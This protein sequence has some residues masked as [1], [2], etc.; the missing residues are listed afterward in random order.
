MTNKAIYA[1][2][3]LLLTAMLQSCAASRKLHEIRSGHTLIETSVCD[4]HDTES[5]VDESSGTTIRPVEQDSKGSSRNEQAYVLDAEIDESTGEMVAVEKINPV[6]ITAKF[7]NIPERGGE[8][9]IAFDIDIPSSYTGNNWQTRIYPVFYM[10]SDTVRGR[11]L[12]LTGKEYRKK[13]MKGYRLY[14]DYLSKII[15]DSADFIEN[16]THRRLLENF[17][18]RNMPE[19][20]ALMDDSSGNDAS[21][22]FGISASRTIR[23]YSMHSKIRFNEKLKAD[24]GKMHKKF[25]KSP[26]ETDLKKDSVLTAYESDIRYM[27]GK[28]IAVGPGIK[29]IKVEIKGGIYENGKLI[30][31]IP[32]SD[33]LVFHI[34]SIGDLA[35]ESICRIETSGTAPAADSNYIKGVEALKKRKYAEALSRLE[36]YCDYNTAVAYLCAGRNKEA[37]GVLEKLPDSP[38]K[39]YALAVAH[40]RNGNK[41]KAVE[42][43]GKSVD[44]DPSMKFRGNL[45]PEIYS[46]VGKYYVL[47]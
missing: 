18:D 34:S 23:H 38:K 9:S 7:R 20:F 22:L 40:A 31:R 46:I 42:C 19:S 41:D 29:K 14:E 37:I 32:P 16:F 11:A 3:L 8:V 45:D 2:C 28:S 13:Q 12:H 24:K 47:N 21:G 15:P 33:P 6:I 35:D 10:Q 4:N 44:S 5:D 27:Y 25:I 1:S 43:Y 26:I 30:C 17:I 39:N 36:R